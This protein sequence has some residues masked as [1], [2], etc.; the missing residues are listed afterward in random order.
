VS[1]RRRTPLDSAFHLAERQGDL[2]ARLYDAVEGGGLSE[3]DWREVERQLPLATMGNIDGRLMKALEIFAEY[4][5]HRHPYWLRGLINRLRPCQNQALHE[6]VLKSLVQLPEEPL[7]TT[8]TAPVPL[9]E[10][11]RRRG[12]RVQPTP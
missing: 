7:L 9:E 3:E 4:G 2:M 11:L 12:R 1:Q 10:K 5:L 8:M 6:Y